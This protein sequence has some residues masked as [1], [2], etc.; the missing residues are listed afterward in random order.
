MADD[1]RSRL[2]AKLRSK[3]S[4][5][6]SGARAPVVDAQEAVLRACGDDATLLRA[7]TSVLHNPRAAAS[8][9]PLLQSAG[10]VG[11][12]DCSA[13]SGQPSVPSDDEEGPPPVDG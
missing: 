2:R 3:R 9:L 5:R 12:P 6:S 1:A 13:E 8:L 10:S 7:A 4:E 11:P